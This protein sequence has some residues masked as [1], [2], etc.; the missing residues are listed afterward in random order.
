MAEPKITTARITAD[1]L[2]TQ[3]L[4]LHVFE[5]DTSA[6]GFVAKV[7]RLYNGALGR[8]LA[9]G[10]FV[11][12]KGDT[13]VVYPPDPDCAIRRVLL[14]GAGRREDHT[15]ERLRRAVGAAVRVAEK[16]A[17]REM[18]ISVGHVHHLSEHMGDYYAGL[19]AVE[20]AMLAS[21]DYRDLKTQGE[22]SAPRSSVEAVTILAHEDRELDELERA[23]RHGTITAR[24][25]NVARD[26]QQRPGNLATPTFVAE[27]AREIADRLKLKITVLDRDQMRKEGMTAL[28][29]V[30]QGSEEE[31]RFVAMEY[32]G[33]EKNAKPLVLV[34]KGVTFD[35]G[36]ISIKPAD[37][38]EEMKYDM[39]G[40][41]AV[42]GAIHAIAE[43]EL[44]VNVVAL[45][46]LTEN[47]P[48]GAAYKPGDVIGSLLGKTIEVVN[49][50]AEGRLILADA[51]AYAQR[52]DPAAIVDCATLTGACVVALG[53]QAIALMGNNGQLIDQVRA[54]GQRTGERCWPMPLWDEYREQISSTIAD[55]KNSGG[56]AAG[57]ITAGWFLKEFVSDE[58][59]WAHLDIAGTAYRDEAAPYLRKGAAGVPARLLI[60]WVRS[61]AGA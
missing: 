16:M 59:P 42:I 44:K 54:A 7:D 40:A 17:I 21:W 27:R 55:V 38:M 12:Y 20:A 47:M 10:D 11:G 57:S 19:A 14:V 37:R 36:G 15:V 13:L 39:S 8:I 48:S 1:E 56:R 22:D 3:L 34:G 28:L 26:L 46:P 6:T 5:R 53:H 24:G 50:D 43:L 45:T 2:K 61:R 52:F 23:V 33:G 58:T 29:A 31:P 41:A 4:V 25:A 9:S 35:T 30:A 49:T 51:L 32:R 18:S 60:D